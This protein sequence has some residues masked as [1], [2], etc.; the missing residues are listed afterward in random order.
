M[1]YPVIISTDQKLM[2]PRQGN[3]NNNLNAQSSIIHCLKMCTCI[4]TR[5]L[6]GGWRYALQFTDIALFGTSCAG[7]HF[8]SR[9][10]KSIQMQL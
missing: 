3:S 1:F 7:C 4:F 8:E 6:C 9:I 2:Y 10:V 5:S